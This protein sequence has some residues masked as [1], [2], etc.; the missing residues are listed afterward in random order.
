MLVCVYYWHMT[1][2]PE[3]YFWHVFRLIS[4]SHH[5]SLSVLLRLLAWEEFA[6]GHS[7]SLACVWHLEEGWLLPRRTKCLLAWADTKFYRALNMVSVKQ[8]ELCKY[9]SAQQMKKDP[10]ISD[11]T[12]KCYKRASPWLT[13]FWLRKHQSQINQLDY[14]DPKRPSPP[15]VRPEC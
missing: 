8:I 13:Q 9:L 1:A 3:H 14:L 7:S 15:E 6:H 2:V 5:L 12:L 10:F 11:H 4:W